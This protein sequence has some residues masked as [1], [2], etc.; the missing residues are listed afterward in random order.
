MPTATPSPATPAAQP[1]WLSVVV[2]TRNRPG[3]LA[4]ALQG[5]QNQ[6]FQDYE[7]IVVDDGSSDATRA[8]Y[9]ALGQLLGARFRFVLLG[10]PAQ[11][12]HGPS[13]ARNFGIH[14]AQGQVISFCDDDDHWCDPAHLAMSAA[15]DESYTQIDYD[16][17]DLETARV[18]TTEHWEVLGVDVDC[19]SPLGDFKC[20]HIR[21]TRTQGGVAVKEYLLARGIGKI[22]EDGGQIEQL[23]ACSVAP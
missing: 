18:P 20:L 7:V 22:R 8:Q 13:V 15:W 14:Q 4:L 2:A 3:L 5:I 21:R 16:A 1:P 9:P 6:T 10:Q 11:P 12:G 17:S 23:T 19:S